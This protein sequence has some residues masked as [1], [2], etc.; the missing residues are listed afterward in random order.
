[1]EERNVGKQDL[2]SAK[3]LTSVKDLTSAKDLTLMLFKGRDSPYH[4]LDYINLT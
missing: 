3:D 1:M 4:K 2:S